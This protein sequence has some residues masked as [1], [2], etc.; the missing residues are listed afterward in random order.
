MV[1][2]VH[3]K[4]KLLQRIRRIR[5]QVNAVE[6]AL[7]EEQDCSSVLMTL[8][9]TRGAINSLMSKVLETHVRFH[10]LSQDGKPSSKQAQA[11]DELV[12]VIRTY[13]K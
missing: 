6:Q 8:A 3:D 11:A 10:V 9:A 12:D 7:V 4:E 13:L 1:H 5:G 2:T